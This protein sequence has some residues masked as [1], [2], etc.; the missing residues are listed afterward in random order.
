MLNPIPLLSLL[1]ASSSFISVSAQDEQELNT[2]TAWGPDNYGLGTGPFDMPYDQWNEYLDDPVATGSVPLPLPD[3]TK[4]FTE[5]AL[6]DSNTDAGWSWTIDLAEGLPVEG[7]DNVTTSVRINLNAPKG[8]AKDIDD[9]WQLCLIRWQLKEGTN[10]SSYFDMRK[11]DDCSGLLTEECIR[12]MEEAAVGDGGTW[13]AG[14]DCPRTEGIESCKGQGFPLWST[15]SSG[16]KYPLFFFSYPSTACPYLTS[17]KLTN[18]LRKN[19]DQSQRNPQMARRQILEH[20]RLQ[21]HA[22]PGRRCPRVQHDG[23]H[24]LANHA[25]LGS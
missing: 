24:L 2:T 5:D 22:P 20:H 18:P 10:T 16:C 12:D 21:R 25:S 19:R 15:C 6:T 4:P 17:A 9:S 3:F 1:L 11:N 14:C 7:T 23:I 8:T 13:L